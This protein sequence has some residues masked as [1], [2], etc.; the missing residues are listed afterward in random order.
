MRTLIS[1]LFLGA[2]TS[3]FASL[4]PRSEAPLAQHMREVN[5]QWIAQDPSP[6]N[7][8]TTVRFTDE[9]DRIHT[10]LTL[11]REQLLARHAEGISAQQLAHRNALLQHL[12]DYAEARTFPQ[13]HVLSY[14]NPVFI[15]PHGTACAVG[16]LMIESGH[17]DLAE[18]ISSTMNLAYLLDM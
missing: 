3:C 14:R 4:P 18:R 10:H 5:A 13:N 6:M 15:D 1:T 12:G 7:A 16:W 11:V 9:A 17:R 8:G 2:T